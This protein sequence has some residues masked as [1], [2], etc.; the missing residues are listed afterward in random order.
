MEKTLQLVDRFIIQIKILQGITAYD[1]NPLRP[2]V[3]KMQH[4]FKTV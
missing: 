2:T 3:A 1:F 4:P